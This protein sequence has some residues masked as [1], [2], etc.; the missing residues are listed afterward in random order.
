MHRPTR[1]QTRSHHAP[2]VSANSIHDGTEQRLR[3]GQ[4]HASHILFE[5]LIKARHKAIPI[6]INADPSVEITGLAK[7]IACG[8][9]T[10]AVGKLPNGARR[11]PSVSTR[12]STWRMPLASQAAIHGASRKPAGHMGVGVSL[13]T[14][15]AFHRSLMPAF[16][17][18][19]A[20]TEP[21]SGHNPATDVVG[22]GLLAKAVRQ[23]QMS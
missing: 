14:K 8:R 2:A 12:V 3:C 18:K 6:K 23:I 20:P 22:A 19:A 7:D 4:P 16:A 11:L 17:T 13:L 10:R 21:C 9:A 5:V 1:Q 15:G